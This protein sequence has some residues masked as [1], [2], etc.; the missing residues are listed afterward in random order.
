MPLKLESGVGVCGQ[1]EVAEV[2]RDL[3]QM[4]KLG[5][6]FYFYM[7]LIF[8]LSLSRINSYLP[9]DVYHQLAADQIT[10][11]AFGWLKL[12]PLALVHWGLLVL[13]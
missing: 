6:F 3:I 1:R 10:I 4:E 11:T 13:Y 7:V 5:F 12:A 9:H 2:I 8:S